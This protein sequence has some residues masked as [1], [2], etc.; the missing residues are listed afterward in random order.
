MVHVST[1]RPSLGAALGQGAGQGIEQFANRKTLTK[2]F[3]DLNKPGFEQKSYTQQLGTLLPALLSVPGG[4]QLAGELAP[5]LSQRAN[6]QNYLNYLDQRRSARANS[7]GQAAAPTGENMGVM[8]QGPEGEIATEGFRNPAEQMQRNPQAMTSPESTTPLQTMQNQAAQP[9]TAD[10][11]QDEIENVMRSSMATGKPISYGEA[12]QIVQ[13]DQ[14]NR[15]RQNEMLEADKQRRE[16]SFDKRRNEGLAQ[17]KNS[18]LIKDPYEEPIFTKFL[19]EGKNA[20]NSNE[21]FLYAKNKF[22][23]YKNARD[24]IRRSVD[25]PNPIT[26]T[27]RKLLGTYQD[28]ESVLKNLQPQIKIYKDLNLIEPLRNDLATTVGL[29]PEDIETAIYPPPAQQKKD[30][31]NFP[32]N[33]IKPDKG[34]KLFG[35]GGEEKTLFDKFPGEGY[36]LPSDKFETFKTDIAKHLQK[37]PETNLIA[38][39]GFLNQSGK[40]AWQDISKAVNELEE[41]GRFKPDQVQLDEKFIINNAPM[42][43]MAQ[44]FRNI[45]TEAK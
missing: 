10:Q 12:N 42:P 1:T 31:E 33:S 17:A 36:Q 28:K 5:V 34:F 4:A 37:Y 14:A 26:G 29:G 27:Y 35:G 15:I 21:Q 45:L 9:M 39:R 23:K 40:Y 38:M 24:T 8:V 20:K 19:D 7:K 30:W 18:G 2:A 44:F 16:E 13:Q 32:K 25:A 11:I 3:E 6:N 43:G 41:E 22:D